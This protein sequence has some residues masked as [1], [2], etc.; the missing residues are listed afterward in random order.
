MGY[1]KTSIMD[2]AQNE[3]ARNALREVTDYTINGKC[4]ECGSCCSDFLPLSSEEIRRIKAYINKHRL[5]AH[6]HVPVIQ[7]DQ[8]DFT[9]PFRDDA[10]AQCDIYEIR[11][12]I[13]RS[14]M[15]N[16][17]KER[18]KNCK[19][20]FHGRYRSVSMRETFFYDPRNSEY[21]RKI[22][23]IFPILEL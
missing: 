16:Y 11:P 21:I 8:L 10:S 19:D 7:I 2:Y 14:F 13:C 15:C 23:S 17:E 5:K 20:K 6:S 9:C 1:V 18:C 3:D 4:S 22:E 12:A